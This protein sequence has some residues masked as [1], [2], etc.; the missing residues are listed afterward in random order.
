M[1]ILILGGTGFIGP[2]VVRR[3]A[4]AHEVTVFTRGKLHPELPPQVRLL[5][6][7]YHDLAAYAG[8]FAKLVPEVVVDMIP[9]TQEDARRVVAEFR[10]IA[11][12]LVV[13]SSQDVYRAWGYIAGRD[14]G[15]VDSH[16]HEESP[17]RASRFPYRGRKLPIYQEWDL[18]NYDKILVEQVFQSEPDLPATILRL[19]MIYGPGDPG[20]RTLPY[21]KRMDDGRRVIPISRPAARM[22][23]P[24]GFVE[25]VA[26]AIALAVTNEAATGRV[27]NVAESDHLSTAEFVEAVGEAAGWS[28]EVVELEPGVLAGPWDAF[29]LDQDVLTDSTRIRREL[30]YRET[31]PRL[32]AL[33]RTIA[34]QRGHVPEPFPA[35][36]FDYAGE[37]QALAKLKGSTWTDQTLSHAVML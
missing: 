30:G 8:E 35:Q 6:G 18:D 28:G 3:L 16:I 1:R 29:R 32:E 13:A 14:A 9:I 25:D 10:G 36:L 23:L 24:L 33:R 15:P 22:R 26:E 27:Y 2:H 37:D 34:W 7:D 19:P 12:R 21:L 11:R 5:T 20:H 31:V 17:L 4:D